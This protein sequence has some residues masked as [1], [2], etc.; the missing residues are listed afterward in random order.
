MVCSQ[1]VQESIKEI[2]IVIVSSNSSV[3][4][5]KLESLKFSFF[6]AVKGQIIRL[7]PFY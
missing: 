1:K 3:K 5:F 7:I 4:E 6:S 2:P